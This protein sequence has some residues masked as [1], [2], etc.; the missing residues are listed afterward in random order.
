MLD[1]ILQPESPGGLEVGQFAPR[2]DL[3]PSNPQR[4][5][6]IDQGDSLRHLPR[7]VRRVHRRPLFLRTAFIEPKPLSDLVEQRAQRGGTRRAPV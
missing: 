6:A 1:G 2:P 4:I 7:R 3:S 5:L